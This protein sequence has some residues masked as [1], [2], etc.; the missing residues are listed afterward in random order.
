MSSLIHQYD[1]C[2]RFEIGIDEAGRGPMFGPLYVA[3]VILPTDLTEFRYDWM[4]DSKKFT[5]KKRL[6]EVAKH[7]K[8][9]A[10]AWHVASV[11]VETIDRINI[12]Q[13]VFSGMHECIREIVRKN[14]ADNP[15]SDYIG[16]IDGND[17]KPYSIYDES[18]ETL[19]YMRH[20]TFEKGDG[21]FCSIA[22]A[23]IL[24]KYER[25]THILELCRR[26]PILAERYSI[27]TNMGYGT[28]V[29]MTAIAEHG[30][31][32]GHRRSY[33]LC[34]TAVLTPLV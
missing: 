25:D 20:E 30:I 28:K 26:Y 15:L 33:G 7:I 9:H 34:K 27:D 23:S 1:I 8:D 21:R 19:E 10:V 11:S 5:S 6:A 2:N 24:A 3:G 14:G 22:A 29:H 13:A 4:K 17:F 16:L 12:R 31:V 32:D 18:A